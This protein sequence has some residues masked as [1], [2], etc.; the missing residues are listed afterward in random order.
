MIIKLPKIDFSLNKFLSV[1]AILG[2]S[3]IIMLTINSHDQLISSQPVFLPAVS[4]YQNFIAGAGIIEAESENIKLSS[5][6]AGIV[7]QVYVKVGDKVNAGDVLFSLDSRQARIN[8]KI[9]E[10]ALK[11]AKANISKSRAILENSEHRLRLAKLLMDKSVISKEE[12][13]TRE[14]MMLVNKAS[15][16]SSEAQYLLAESELQLARTNVEILTVKAPISCNILQINVRPGEYVLGA[17]N[18]PLML[19]GTIKNM[20]VRVDIDE[21]E[22][23]R[24]RANRKATGY[25]RGNSN[26]KFD[27]SYVKTEPYILPKKSL[28]GEITERV[29]TRVLQV[30]YKFTPGHLPLYIGQQIDVFIESDKDPST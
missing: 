18:N 21:Q 5:L 12:Y 1:L 14:N 30:I 9:K 6:Q 28:T 7:D 19:L 23:W 25:I 3:S 29:D 11:D 13:I 16:E 27:L 8:I 26:L 22:A 10:A 2:F 17:S 15:Y 4:P 20:H 24:F